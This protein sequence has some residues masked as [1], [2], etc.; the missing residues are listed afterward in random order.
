MVI[1]VLSER[2]T[3][4][5]YRQSLRPCRGQ[6]GLRNVDKLEVWAVGMGFTNFSLK[7]VPDK[8]MLVKLDEQPAI[9]CRSHFP[10]FHPLKGSLICH[11]DTDGKKDTCNGDSGGPLFLVNPTTK[12]PTCVYGVVSYGIKDKGCGRP[13]SPTV[14]ARVASYIDMFNLS[15]DRN[16]NFTQKV[17]RNEHRKES[18]DEVL[19]E[20]VYY[21]SK[22]WLMLFIVIYRY[23]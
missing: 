5:K 12:L 3:F 17:V 6:T 22:Q 20:A 4:D 15:A 2:M 13:K 21:N 7:S 18:I 8:L 10:N 16:T 19:S 23:N 9:N 1:L 14:A 11:D